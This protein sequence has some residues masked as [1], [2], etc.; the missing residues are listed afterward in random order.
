MGCHLRAAPDGRAPRSEYVRT[1]SAIGV[2][3]PAAS[4]AHEQ[5]EVPAIDQIARYVPGWV[6]TRSAS[7][8]TCSGG[9]MWSLMPPSRKLGQSTADKFTCL[10]S[11]TSTPRAS[12]LWTNRCSMIQS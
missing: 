1:R 9:V 5:T 2:Q 7:A 3:R 8:Q 6:A 4:A 10:P 11:T 12:S